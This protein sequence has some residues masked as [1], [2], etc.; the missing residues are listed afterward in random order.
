MITAERL[1]EVL[2]YNPETG[3]FIWKVCLAGRRKAGT[4]AGCKRID[5]RIVIRIDGQLIMA[6][7]LAWLYMTGQYPKNQIDHIDTDPTNNAF[8]NLREATESENRWNTKRRAN[9]TSGQKGVSWCAERKKWVA[10]I[11]V[12]RKII[13]LGR[14]S[15]KQDAVM[16]YA[17]AAKKYHGEFARVN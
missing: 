10:R 13:S 11:C 8:S 7:R 6:H 16:A 3:V 12:Y 9:N 14:F 1:R 15:K 4:I 2:N 17:S 5:N